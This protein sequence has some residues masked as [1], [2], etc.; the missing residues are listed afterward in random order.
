MAQSSLGDEAS[1]RCRNSAGLTSALF[2]LALFGMVT[3]AS[4]TPILA[5]ASG[6][7]DRPATPT[8]FAWSH[9]DH[10][11]AVV[12]HDPLA[13]CDET[14]YRRTDELLEWHVNF[15]G[16]GGLRVTSD[17]RRLPTCGR[18]Q[19]DMQTYLANGM[20]NPMGMV[21]LVVN[22]G[23]NCG[24]Q[25]LLPLPPIAPPPV[26]APEPATM[27]LFATGLAVLL[28]KLR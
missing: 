28:T 9:N 27:T 18:L 25:P 22:L 17:S 7:V 21:S 2:L 5:T 4:A 8:E 11:Q 1:I 13:G 15:D 12:F 10:F 26:P 16:Q 20:L 24:T 23:S 6:C 19:F 14:I 3:T